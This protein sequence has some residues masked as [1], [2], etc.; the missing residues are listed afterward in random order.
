MIEDVEKKGLITPIKS[1]L[2][3]PTSGNMGIR[4]AFMAAA[5]GYK[6]TLT[7]PS[8]ISLERR[9][10]LRAFGANLALTDPT[11]G[12]GGT[13]RRRTNFWRLTLRPSCFSSSTTL[14][15]LRK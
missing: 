2:I 12:M 9:V 13:V 10:P 11:K 5:K 7:M 4:L 3:E 6:L 8:Y 1:M 14:L 15:M